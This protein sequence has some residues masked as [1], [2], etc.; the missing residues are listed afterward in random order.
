MGISAHAPHPNAA[1]LFLDF[2]HSEVAQITLLEEG[3]AVGRLG[4]KSKH[5][6]FPRPIYDIKAIPVDWRK[7][8][9]K[10]RNNAR[11]EF[12]RLVIEKK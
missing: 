7:I 9:T 5:P 4:L 12:R 8:T 2:F 1:K 6:V 11:E 10:D 3:Y